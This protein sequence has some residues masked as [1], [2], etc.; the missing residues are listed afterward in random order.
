LNGPF[1]HHDGLS[2]PLE[3]PRLRV[4]SL[5][6]GVQSTTLA[7]MAARG[8]IE[9]PDCAIF[10]DTCS[11][12]ASVYRHLEWLTGVL[13]FPVHVVSAGSLRDQIVT[14]AK[15]NVRPPMFIIGDDGKVGLTNRQ[16]TQDFKIIPIGRKVRELLGLK[17]GT[18]G[19][20]SPVVEQ[21]IGI[22]TDEIVR[23]KRSRF[24]YIHMRHPLIEARMSRADCLIWLEERQYPTPPKSACTFC[25]FHS[26]AMWREMKAHDP[27]SFADAVQ[28]DNALRS[29]EI[30]KK[31]VPYLHRSCI[32]LSDV[33]F[34][35]T[36]P[37]QS[38]FGFN[39]ECE[40]MCGV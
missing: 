22:S 5:G 37:R 6:A 33:E 25:P 18:R 16:C 38:I 15:K 8:E 34:S 36:D 19:P 21:W 17:P 3:S 10:A 4:L 9:A 23:L 14:G 40:G 26:D 20:K 27:E 7:L 11:E 1:M 39:N 12:P 2:R 28:V 13:P 31:G 35:L 30:V 29:G 32:P 24:S